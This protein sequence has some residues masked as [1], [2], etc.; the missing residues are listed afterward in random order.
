MVQNLTQPSCANLHQSAKLLRG[1]GFAL[2]SLASLAGIMN[3]KTLACTRKSWPIVI[4]YPNGELTANRDPVTKETSF[5]LHLKH[6]RENIVEWQNM[7]VKVGPSVF[8]RIKNGW[9]S[10]QQLLRSFN[11]F[12]S[13]AALSSWRHTQNS[14]EYMLLHNSGP[15]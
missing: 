11:L 10:W 12:A 3:K 7:V 9:R 14:F 1:I 5:G 2:V 4:H 13:M 15:L 8:L 6:P